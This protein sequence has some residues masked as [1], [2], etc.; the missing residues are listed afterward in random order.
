MTNKL[1]TQLTATIASVFVSGFLFA[2]SPLGLWKTIDDKTGDDKSI[3]KLEQNNMGEVTGTVIQILKLDDGST[4]FADKRCEKCSGARKGQKI[5][6]MKILWGA[7]QDGKEWTGGE[8]LDP[9]TGTIYSCKFYLNE[10]GSK[11]NVRG[12]IGFSLIGRTQVWQRLSQQD[13]AKYGLSS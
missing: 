8:I 10:D 12:F 6:G 11:L 5:Q 4:N 1:I 9:K 13:L 2:S 7:R 3:V